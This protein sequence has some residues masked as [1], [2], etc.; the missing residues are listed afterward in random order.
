MGP[1]V[2]SVPPTD[3]AQIVKNVP[4][5]KMVSVMKGFLEM[6]LVTVLKDG[7]VKIARSNWLLLLFA[8]RNVTV[9][10]PAEP[11]MNVN[12]TLITTEMEEHAL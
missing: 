5:L 6:D 11:I 4:A 1:L 3:M 7:L 8:P 9:M 12:V 10:P 2:K